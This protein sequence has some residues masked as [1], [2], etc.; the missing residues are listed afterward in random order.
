MQNICD[1][2]VS[3]GE[4]IKENVRS[5]IVMAAATTYREENLEEPVI[6]FMVFKYDQGNNKT[7]WE[8]EEG[9]QIDVGQLFQKDLKTPF[10]DKVNHITE[11]YL[12]KLDNSTNTT[13]SRQ[14][15]SMFETPS[16]ITE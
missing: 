6:I 4:V 3:L 5:A 14:A 11:M 9:H 15:F 8:D 16:G 7:V 10:Q 12:F 1:G 2:T 13:N